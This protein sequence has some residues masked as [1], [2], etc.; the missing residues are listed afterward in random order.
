MGTFSRVLAALLLSAAAAHAAPRA[1]IFGGYQYT[2]LQGGT[3]MNGWTGALT[4]NTGS[5]L[6]ITADFSGVYGSGLDLYTYS[7]GPEIH[8]H[9]PIVKPF[10]HALFG[11]ARLSASGSSS[12][13][14]A[15]YLGGGFDV[16]HGSIAWRVAQ[17]DWLYTDFSGVHFNRNLRYATGLVLRF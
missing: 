2:H 3:N 7:F 17:F 12:R 10:V 8:A 4:G 11:G 6:G 9:L 15:M 16:G 14:F 5:L 1:E 13:G